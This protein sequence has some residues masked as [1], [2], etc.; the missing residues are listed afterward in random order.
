NPLLADALCCPTLGLDTTPCSVLCLTRRDC[1][2]ASG[3]HVPCVRRSGAR[4]R[5]LTARPAMGRLRAAARLGG[6]TRSPRP[7]AYALGACPG[8]DAPQTGWDTIAP[9][10]GG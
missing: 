9:G 8:P 6:V 2:V 1:I 3:H 10:G 5:A 7:A 4:Q